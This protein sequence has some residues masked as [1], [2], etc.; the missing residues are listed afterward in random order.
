MLKTKSC[1]VIVVL[2]LSAIVGTGIVLAEEEPMEIHIVVAPSALNL[3]ADLGGECEDV[4]VHT[5]I[6]YSKFHA[7]GGNL[8][9]NGV[10]VA[11]TK[12]DN[13]GDLVAKF[14]RT[15]VED[16]A[17]VGEVTLTLTGTTL[18]GVSITGSDTIRVINGGK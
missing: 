2:V 8:A 10:S 5:D 1:G 18:D 3:N 4:T 9:L 16:I 7:D 13:R 6:A 17:A 14:D 11:W 15:A 12:A